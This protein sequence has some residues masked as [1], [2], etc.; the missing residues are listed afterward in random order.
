[1]MFK[2]GQKK[3]QPEVDSPLQGQ[4]CVLWHPQ[5]ARSRSEDELVCIRES[6]RG[7]TGRG[8]GRLGCREE[9][10]LERQIQSWWGKRKGKGDDPAEEEQNSI[11]GLTNDPVS[12]G[13]VRDGA[14]IGTR[15]HRPSLNYGMGNLRG[16]LPSNTSV[17]LLYSTLLV[18]FR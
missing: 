2:L 9:E 7:R 10:P 15:N 11:D 18:F 5:L 16:I 1:M 6:S 13:R 3:I 12:G 4:P 17:K 8:R 14:R